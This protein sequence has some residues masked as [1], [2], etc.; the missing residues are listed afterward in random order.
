MVKLYRE[1]SYAK[2]KY[3]PLIVDK[4]SEFKSP[5]Y[6]TFVQFCLNEPGSINKIIFTVS[7]GKSII[8]IKQNK[9]YFYKLIS[10][11]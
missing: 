7:Y 8:H 1:V 4:Y 9:E 6:A 11:F 10:P 5:A 2:N 3:I